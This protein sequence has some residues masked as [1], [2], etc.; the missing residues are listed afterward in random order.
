M[1]L[2]ADNQACNATM[3]LSCQGMSPSL[4]TH[5]DG[6]T[7][8]HHAAMNG[9]DACVQMLIASGANPN[10]VDYDGMT[11]LH[12]A[13]CGGSDTCVRTLIAGGASP[14]IVNY[15][16]LSP[17]HSAAQYGLDVC[18]RM[19]ITAGARPD[20]VDDLGNTPLDVALWEGHDVC[21]PT[22]IAYGANLNVA[23]TGVK[24]TNKS[25]AAPTNTIKGFFQMLQKFG[26]H[27]FD[28]KV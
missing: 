9:H 20:V 2:P 4:S 23:N 15:R 26:R 24:T 22:L 5:A 12:M 18:I 21:V 6:R 19:L 27:P 13:V 8:L 16:G 7:A 25:T 14:H 11:P 1:N 3:S 17:L 28:I 10:V